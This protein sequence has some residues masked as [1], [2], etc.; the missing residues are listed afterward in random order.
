MDG[1]AGWGLANLKAYKMTGRQSL[2]DRA[3]EAAQNLI[4][5]AREDQG[6]SWPLK[7]EIHLGVF[8]GS[9][10]IA[11]FLLFVGCATQ[12]EHMLEAARN[13]LRFDLMRAKPNCDGGISWSYTTTHDTILLP[14]IGYGTAGVASAALRFRAYLG[15]EA[16]DE[17]L[18]LAYLDVDRK[19]TATPGF[20]YGLTGIGQYHLD[21]IQLL[22]RSEQHWS[23]L[24]KVHAGL[25]NF[26]V[27]RTDGLAFASDVLSRISCDWGFG[28]A[29]IVDFLR[30][31]SL[32]GY[33]LLFRDDLFA[34]FTP[35]KT[36]TSK[37]AILAS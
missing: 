16:L 13:A 25:Q 1:L 28:V 19:Y 24:R 12:D 21:A 18:R 17:T 14:Y 6:W 11:T 33:N 30:R 36:L 23:S 35:R 9:T 20:F 8:F 34:P 32:G 2:L 4:Q 22:G 5:S 3:V 15:D 37:D 10:G 27:E 26:K 31:L 7:E 29:G